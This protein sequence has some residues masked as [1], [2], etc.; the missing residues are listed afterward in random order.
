MTIFVVKLGPLLFKAFYDKDTAKKYM[1]TKMEEP[2][3][4]PDWSWG[5]HE[6]EIGDGR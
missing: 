3:W 1:R 4:Y 6:L 2:N 5:V